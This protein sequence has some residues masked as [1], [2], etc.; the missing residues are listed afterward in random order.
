MV[1]LWIGQSTTNFLSWSQKQVSLS[2][3]VCQM[4]EFYCYQAFNKFKTC[5]LETGDTQADPENRKYVAGKV[6]MTV[7]GRCNVGHYC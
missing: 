1:F 3:Y 4:R 5:P 6:I 2:W 7:K